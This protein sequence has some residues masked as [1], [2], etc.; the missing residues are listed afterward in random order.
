[1]K[2][3]HYFLTISENMINE[4]LLCNNLILWEHILESDFF[5]LNHLL[6][7]FAHLFKPSVSQ[8]PNLWCGESYQK[9]T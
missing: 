1:M 9:L 8:F 4:Q 7:V 6:L 3:Q 5:T 2:Q